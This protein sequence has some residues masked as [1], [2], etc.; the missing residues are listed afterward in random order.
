MRA[1]KPYNYLGGICVNSNTKNSW[2]VLK[3]SDAHFFILSVSLNSCMLK[4]DLH[5]LWVNFLN[6]IVV[7]YF[8]ILELPLEMINKLCSL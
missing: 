8:N 6:L 4:P 2:A 7:V 3:R 1:P 5:L